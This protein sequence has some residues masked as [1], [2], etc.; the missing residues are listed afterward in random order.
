M[1]HRQGK[2][3]N[4]CHFQSFSKEI[5]LHEIPLNY[6]F[7]FHLFRCFSFVVRR[8]HQNK[9]QYFGSMRQIKLGAFVKQRWIHGVGQ[10]LNVVVWHMTGLTSINFARK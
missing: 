7:L 9:H 5:N 1:D 8:F 10:R 2:L 4:L 3:S 6:S